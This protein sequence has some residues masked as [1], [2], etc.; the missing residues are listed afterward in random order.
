MN[1]E[2]QRI[3]RSPFDYWTHHFG[4]EVFELKISMQWLQLQTG[5]SSMIICDESPSFDK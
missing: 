3:S 2:F 1:N 5:S 4:L